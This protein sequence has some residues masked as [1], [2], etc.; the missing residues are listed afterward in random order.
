MGM[1]AIPNLFIG[2]DFQYIGLDIKR[3]K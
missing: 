2:Y 1:L 3:T